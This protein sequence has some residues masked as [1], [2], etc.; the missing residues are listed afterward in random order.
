MMAER[1]GIYEQ[2]KELCELSG[3]QILNCFQDLQCANH[4]FHFPVEYFL[5]EEY[6]TINGSPVKLCFNY[7]P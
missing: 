1:A 4:G 2:S 6:L 3:L 5:G 7:N